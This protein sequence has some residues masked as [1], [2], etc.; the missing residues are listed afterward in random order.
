LP[1]P[2]DHTGL[3]DPRTPFL[4]LNLQSDSVCNSNRNFKSQACAPLKA[5]RACAKP[6]VC[7]KFVELILP[8][9]PLCSFSL[10]LFALLPLRLLSLPLSSALLPVLLSAHLR[11]PPWFSL[12]QHPTDPSHI[13]CFAR[14]FSLLAHLPFCFFLSSDPLPPAFP[15]LFVLFFLLLFSF[16]SPFLPPAPC[17]S[18]LSF[19]F[20]YLLYASSLPSLTT[21]MCDSRGSAS[22]KS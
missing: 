7:D 16:Y 17:P 1:V 19:R 20:F 3:F 12:H 15:L 4:L 6:S 11:P 21:Y 2:C 10:S 18:P 5:P 13:R 22:I 8:F 14:F 9:P